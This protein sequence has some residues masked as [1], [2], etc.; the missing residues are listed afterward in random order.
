MGHQVACFIQ[1]FTPCPGPVRL[2]RQDA[3]PCARAGLSGK[4]PQHVPRD[5]MQ[6]PARGKVRLA[7]GDPFPHVAAFAL[8]QPV[9]VF[10]LLLGHIQGKYIAHVGHDRVEL[11]G[12]IGE[13]FAVEL[14]RLQ[15]E[16]LQRQPAV[17]FEIL[18]QVR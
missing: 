10:R 8:N 6:P 18:A 11:G 14:L 2:F 13:D 17:G 15:G 9:L 1:H 16:V 4:K 5:L 3:T 7:V 12:A